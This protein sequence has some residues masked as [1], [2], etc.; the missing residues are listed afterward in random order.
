MYN[1]SDPLAV[2]DEF[3]L[4]PN[5]YLELDGDETLESF[6]KLIGTVEESVAE[7]PTMLSVKSFIFKDAVVVLDP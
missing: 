7:P 1:N 4:I 3:K 5:K 6:V 2:G